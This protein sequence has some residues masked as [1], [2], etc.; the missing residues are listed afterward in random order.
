[1]GEVIVREEGHVGWIILSNLSR[2]NAVT[3]AM[4]RAIP[5]A[6]QRLGSAPDIRIVAISGDGDEAL[7]SGGDISEFETVRATREADAEYT[8]AVDEAC[9]APVLCPKPV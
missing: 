7:V 3:Y 1:M 9:M 2:H 4:W 8:R 6:L 5:E